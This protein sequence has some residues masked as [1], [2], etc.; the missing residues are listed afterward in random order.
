MNYLT[1]FRNYCKRTEISIFVILS[2]FRRQVV[3]YIFSSIY[4]QYVD[5]FYFKHLRRPKA[6]R[7]RWF[8]AL[9]VCTILQNPGP[10]RIVRCIILYLLL[11]RNAHKP[12]WTN[13]RTRAR[14]HT[15]THTHTHIHTHGDW[16]KSSLSHKAEGTVH[17][18]LFAIPFFCESSTPHHMSFSSLFNLST[19]TDDL[20][21]QASTTP[22]NKYGCHGWNVVYRKCM[23]IVFI[24][25]KPKIP[26]MS[27]EKWQWRIC[28]YSITATGDNNRLLKTT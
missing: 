26:S 16:L 11:Y 1:V 28:V 5:K 18:Y 27:S 15:H 25:F 8:P 14:T 4:P 7:F 19:M 22:T 24:V 23:P 10:K 2:R 20:C 13:A 12:R 6:L 21:L 3:V 9:L 17:L